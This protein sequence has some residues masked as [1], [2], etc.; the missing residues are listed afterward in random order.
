MPRKMAI[1][2]TSIAAPPLL[3]SS[4][5]LLLLLELS[6]TIQNSDLMLTCIIVVMIPTK[7]MLVMSRRV[8][9]LRI[10]V[11]SWAITPASSSSLSTFSSPVVTVTV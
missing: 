11:S 8:S 2:N 5:S 3:L 7:M 1:R 9:R 10:C 6:L 4:S